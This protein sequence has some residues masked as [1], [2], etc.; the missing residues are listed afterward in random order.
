MI[1]DL[2]SNNKLLRNVSRVISVVN[3]SREK[4]LILRISKSGSCSRIISLN[5]LFAS[6]FRDNP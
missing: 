3:N 1:R 4:F 6:V 5:N 2:I